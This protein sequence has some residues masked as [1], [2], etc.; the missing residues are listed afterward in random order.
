M[1]SGLRGL[2]EFLEFR[3]FLDLRVHK[4]AW[5]L[6]GELVPWAVQELTVLQVRKVQQAL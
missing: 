4:V 1:L 5:V 6:L 2:Q 3:E